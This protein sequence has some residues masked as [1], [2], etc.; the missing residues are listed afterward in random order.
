MEI[1]KLIGS[2][3]VDSA[4]A[5][6]SLQKTDKHAEGVGQTLLKGVGTAAKW[7]AA[8][9]TAATAAVTGVVA[10]AKNTADA[11]SEISGMSQKIGI[12]KQAY[13]ELD[14]VLSQNGMDVNVLQ[15][16]MKKLVNQMSAAQEGTKSA[17][18]AFDALG[19]SATNTDGS[20]RSQEAVFYDTITALQG[21]TNETER[22]AL[23]NDLFGK[24]ASELG[25][26][27]NAG[28]G[29]MEE[30]TRKAHEL[31][32]VMSDDVVNAGETLGDTLETVQSAFGAMG[33]QIGAAA[34]PAVQKFA[35][36][37]IA[38]I[39]T[40]QSLISQ[41][42]PIIMSLLQGLLPPLMSLTESILPVIMT[43]IQTLLPPITQIAAAILPLLVQVI[44]QLLP[45]FLQ[46][47]QAVLPIV[48]Q[49]ITALLPILT[50]LIQLISPI[51]QMVITMIQPLLEISSAILPYLASFIQ[52]VLVP[53][54]NVLIAVVQ[55]VAYSFAK[56]WADIKTAWSAV[57]GFFTGI[58]NSVK[59]SAG[60]VVANL[61]NFF[62]NA[63]SSIKNVYNSVAGF[64]TGVFTDAWNGIKTAFNAVGEFFQ[65]VF[66]TIKSIF[67]T[68]HFRFTG[69]LNPLKWEDEG[70][71]KISVEWYRKGG[72][73]LDPT[74]F[75]INGGNAMVGGEA[76]P[77]AVAP[78]ETLQKY[79][80]DAVGGGAQVQLLEAILSALQK[81]DSNMYE[82]IVKALVSG[83]TFDVDKREFAR[84]V[85]AYA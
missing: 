48:V 66:N 8:I 11:T 70:T 75:G 16:G 58:W 64:F 1:F 83:V 37:I 40:I 78:I 76:G 63:W 13:Q 62:V 30:L 44:E 38:N 24:S 57:A 22:N 47:A 19:V 67:K 12:S 41:L 27:L 85:R 7:G 53:V 14:Y 15:G 71:P 31:G 20:L 77:E 2:V 79:I 74:L 59:S 39:P 55:F 33:N 81:M 10:M 84:L 45:P 5:D 46:L 80:V 4:E 43:L 82:A 61:V 23:A 68:P 32:L 36:F 42:L 28:A 54:L 3:F 29:N 21:M 60:E 26:L 49:L 18:N 51:L 9:V 17:I 56:A 65:G 35:D 73:M 69:T 34:I 52:S 6:A 50:P 72:I 25:P